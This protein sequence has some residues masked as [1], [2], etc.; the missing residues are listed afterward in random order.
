MWI[1]YAGRG[2]GPGEQYDWKRFIVQPSALNGYKAHAWNALNSHGMVGQGDGF[3]LEPG[4]YQIVPFASSACW[5]GATLGCDNYG[6]HCVISPDGRGGGTDASATGQPNTLF[7]WT[8]PGV[9][10]ASLVDGFG[11]PM[12][13]EVDGC[14][15]PFSGSRNDCD[16]SDPQIFLELDPSKCTNPIYNVN[17]KYVGCKSMCGCQNSA[18]Q[19][20]KD[21]DP[22]CPGMAAVSSIRNRPHSPGGYCG[23]P[24]S[25]CVESLRALFDR[26]AAG[27][28]YCDSITQMTAT[29]TGKR[30]VYCQAYD[31]NAGTRSYGNGVLKITF[32]N[33]GFESVAASGGN[34]SM[35]IGMVV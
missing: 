24:E 1:R 21:F 30:A 31:D 19:Q 15:A 11:I 32:C 29:S 22:S 10:D 9:W 16:E 33:K 13:V 6:A 25:D 12:K 14:G 4:E 3:K 26:D 35:L 7:E 17:K 8:A 20:H 2:I 23:C 27:K 5:A 18:E 28:S 34:R